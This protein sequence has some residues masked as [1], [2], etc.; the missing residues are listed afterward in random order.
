LGNISP[1]ENKEGGGGLLIVAKKAHAFTKRKSER[2]RKVTP[3]VC[4][5]MGVLG[6]KGFV[7]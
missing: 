4:L 1:E 2:D 5:P 7:E 6:E 3:G